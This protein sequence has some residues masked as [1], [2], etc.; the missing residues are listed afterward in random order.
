MLELSYAET[1]ET[2]RKTARDYELHPAVLES[3]LAPYKAVD[4]GRGARKATEEA[5][6]TERER[7]TVALVALGN[8][9]RMLVLETLA[10]RAASPGALQA[11]M[12]NAEAMVEGAQERRTARLQTRR[13]SRAFLSCFFPGGLFPLSPLRGHPLSRRSPRRPVRDLARYAGSDP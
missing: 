9:E 11:L 12:R 10:R 6:L 13:R 1:S 5:E 8:Q 3:A 4:G 2:I 7:L